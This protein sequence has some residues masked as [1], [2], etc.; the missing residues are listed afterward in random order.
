VKTDKIF[1]T[2]FREFPQGFFELIG[3]RGDAKRYRV[4][5]SVEIKELSF[6]IDALFV[7]KLKQGIHYILEIQFQRDDAFYSRLF[8]ET[9]LY[10]RQYAPAAN[11]RVVVIFPSRNFEPR[12]T[13][14]Y[15]ELLDSTRVLRVYLDE[16]DLKSDNVILGILKL[17]VETP[18]SV[19]ELTHRL[20]KQVA[21]QKRLLHL[22]E[23]ILF[24]KFSDLTREEIRAMLKIDKELFKETRVYQEFVDEGKAQKATEIAKRLLAKKL[25]LDFV[26]KA[27]GI[28]MAKLR[29]LSS[30]KLST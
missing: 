5:S 4:L 30:K 26:S 16:M 10:L 19:P 18:V 22:I 2:V 9:F 24:Q 20:V 28:S 17:I 12:N 3:R 14:P 11:W 8:S 6:R 25:P 21:G 1:Y 29:A 13:A 27:T 15:R 23:Q 7:P